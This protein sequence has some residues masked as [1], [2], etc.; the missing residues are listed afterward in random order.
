MKAIEIGFW[1]FYC[2]LNGI[3]QDNLGVPA[4]CFPDWPRDKRLE[5]KVLD[6]ILAPRKIC[7]SLFSKVVRFYSGWWKHR[8]VY[9]ENFILTSFRLAK[10][11]LRLKDDRAG[12]IWDA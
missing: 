5:R 8:I 2:C 12:S 11:Y 6:E 4:F 3:V 1:K 9:K 10:S 7:S